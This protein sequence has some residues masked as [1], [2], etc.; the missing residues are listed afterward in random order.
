MFSQNRS[1]G[2]LNLFQKPFLLPI[3]LAQCL[4]QEFEVE[5]KKVSGNSSDSTNLPKY[6]IRG[7]FFGFLSANRRAFFHP[8]FSFFVTTQGRD[9]RKEK[10]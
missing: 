5:G 2:N 6:P 1:K 8:I 3:C 4:Y 10:E 9:L 7:W